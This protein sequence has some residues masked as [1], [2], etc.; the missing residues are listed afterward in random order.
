MPHWTLLEALEEGV[1]ALPTTGPGEDS[2]GDQ[3]GF[4][5]AATTIAAAAIVVAIASTAVLAA[6]VVSVLSYVDDHPPR[7]WFAL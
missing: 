5:G 1:G 2:V 4:V 6:A 3:L 7:L